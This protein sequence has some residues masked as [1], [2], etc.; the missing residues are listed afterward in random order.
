MGSIFWIYLMMIINKKTISA[1]FHNGSVPVWISAQFWTSGS[2]REIAW[3][4]AINPINHRGNLGASKKL[5]KSP[6]KIAGN[7][8][9]QREI[10]K[11]FFIIFFPP[12]NLDP[13]GWQDDNGAVSHIRNSLGP[14]APRR[15]LSLDTA[16]GQ[17]KVQP[18]CAGCT[19]SESSSA[20]APPKAGSRNPSKRYW[21]LVISGYNSKFI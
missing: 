18:P 14:F 11:V 10:K 15:L 17:K 5:Q 19:H 2:D 12:G 16:R 1:G 3:K 21:T 8:D 20:M 13:D 7:H 9:S 4:Q 6:W